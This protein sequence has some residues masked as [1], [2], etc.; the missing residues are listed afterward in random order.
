VDRHY[1]VMYIHSESPKG[2]IIYQRPAQTC[3]GVHNLKCLITGWFQAI[4]GSYVHLP[5]KNSRIMKSYEIVLTSCDVRS[6]FAL[7]LHKQA[8]QLSRSDCATRYIS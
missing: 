5:D 3:T 4:L 6:I 2:T 7:F 1:A 8:A